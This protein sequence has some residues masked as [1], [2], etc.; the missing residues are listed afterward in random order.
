VSTV[1]DLV[2]RQHLVGPAKPLAMKKLGLQKLLLGKLPRP[3]LNPVVNVFNEKRRLT[4]GFLKKPKLAVI[5]KS[6]SGELH[7]RDPL[8]TAHPAPL[9]SM[10]LIFPLSI[11]MI[12]YEKL[13]LIFF[14]VSCS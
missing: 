10:L 6:L 9:L 13:L 11:R 5:A 4:E 3:P 14:M 8:R 2:A 12:R 1:A 7:A